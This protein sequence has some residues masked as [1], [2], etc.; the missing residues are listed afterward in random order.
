MQ[1]DD[2]GEVL[3]AG[4]ALGEVEGGIQ[5]AL[6]QIDE[7]AIEGGGTLAGGIEGPLEGID[8]LFE[9]IL[10]ALIGLAA[11]VHRLLGQSA[12]ALR[13]GGVELERFELFG[14]FT[15]AIARL[16]GGGLWRISLAHIS[17]SDWNHF[18]WG[19]RVWPIRL[20][21][22]PHCFCCTAI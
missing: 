10:A 11:L 1:L 14:G 7:L 22:P 17:T 18:A 6:G 8:G 3:G 19:M 13:H 9:R 15:E 21:G 2:L 20:G 16:L 12:Y 5:I 4:E